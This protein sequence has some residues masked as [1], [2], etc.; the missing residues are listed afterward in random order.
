MVPAETARPHEGAPAKAQRDPTWIYLVGRAL[1]YG[2]MCLWNRVRVEGR[3]HIPREGGVLVV[4]NHQ[5]YL[6][7][8][9]VAGALRRHVVFVARDTLQRSRFLAWVMRG[10]GAI[11]IHRG[12]PDRAALR[13]MR[14]DHQV[15]TAKRLGA[16]GLVH[17]A[18]DE[19]ELRERLDGLMEIG[20]AERIPAT[21][22]PPLIDRLKRFID[23][24]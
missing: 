11:L 9:L 1:S 8:S 24:D 5:S 6:D 21:A 16:R 3:E 13:E 19:H 20:A 23:T 12:A 18:M 10:S 2:A 7:I 22:P 4:A 17:A 14:N 15:A